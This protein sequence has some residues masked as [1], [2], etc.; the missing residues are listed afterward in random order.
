MVEGSIQNSFMHSF[1]AKGRL[2]YT[3]DETIAAMCDRLKSFG[4]RDLAIAK[5]DAANSV[6]PALYK[7]RKWLVTR[8]DY[9]YTSLWILHAAQPFA[10]LEIISAGLLADRETLPQALKLN[11][12]LFT[13]IYTNLLRD[14]TAREPV[15]KAL[16]AIEAAMAAR[17]RDVFAPVIAYLAEVGDV[18]STRDLEDHFKKTYGIC[19]ITSACEYLADLGLIGK[20]STAVQLTKRSNLSLEELAFF[21]LESSDGR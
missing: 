10:K 11:P 17:A 13:T 6:L 5:L 12:A 1:L 3:H 20:A 19:G 7:A 21:F 18:R 4:S 9:A 2:L 8:G 14:G 16:E 15:E